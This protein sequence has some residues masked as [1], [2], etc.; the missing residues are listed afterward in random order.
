MQKGQFLNPKQNY[1]VPLP[2][3]L[4]ETGDFRYSDA[5]ELSQKGAGMISLYLYKSNVA[6][7]FLGAE[8]GNE[9]IDLLDSFD[10][11]YQDFEAVSIP[12]ITPLNRLVEH[13]P[14]YG[15]GWIMFRV[16]FRTSRDDQKVVEKA[17]APITPDFTPGFKF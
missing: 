8:R 2:A 4:I 16:D 13:R 3:L 9:S 10:A 17:M 6:D 12:G 15:P 1:P 14:Q 11:I 7:T 5:G